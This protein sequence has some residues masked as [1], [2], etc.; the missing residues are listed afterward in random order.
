LSVRKRAF[1]R[2]LGTA[3]LAAVA[4]PALES[5]DAPRPSEYEV[6][7][8]FLYNF[9]KFVRWPDDD[10]AGRT[11]VVGVLGKDPF[12]DA[13]DRTFSG[14]TIG[15]R[16]AEVRR[17]TAPETAK[18]VQILFV[19]S[20]E[21]PRLAEILRSLEGS[22]VLTVGEMDSFTDRGGM[23]AFRLRDDLVRFEINL[24]QVK[25]ARLVMSSQLIRLALRVISSQPGA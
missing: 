15:N 5:A 25:R 14:K 24:D 22:S 21:K 19:S 16:K 4:A 18:H 11:F 9:A 3:L 6:K 10:P 17:I 1:L 8:A 13:L 7:A 23:I 2:C 12:G 20:S